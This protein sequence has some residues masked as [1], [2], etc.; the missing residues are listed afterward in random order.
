MSFQPTP[1]ILDNNPNPLYYIPLTGETLQ[2]YINLN[3]PKVKIVI[4][5]P[6]VKIVIF[7]PTLPTRR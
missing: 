3:V 4:F 6:K 5:V 7:T 2:P 1:P